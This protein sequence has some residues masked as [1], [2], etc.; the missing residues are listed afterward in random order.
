MR[1]A[2]FTLLG[3]TF[4]TL[5]ASLCPMNV[6]GMPMNHEGMQMAAMHS[7]DEMKGMNHGDK[8]EVPCKKC[9]KE[10]NVEITISSSTPD[11]KTSNT[12]QVA[13][14]AV[15]SLSIDDLHVQKIKLKNSINGPPL[16]VSLVGTV[17]LRT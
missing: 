5:C 17:V 4:T 3:F 8:K 14:V 12:L 11:V 16:S 9:E 1:L 7:G 13:Y 2:V 10:D 6:G 15:A